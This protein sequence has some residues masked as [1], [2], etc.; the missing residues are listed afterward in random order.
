MIQGLSFHIN[1]HTNCICINFSRSNIQRQSTLCLL[2]LWLPPIRLHPVQTVVI[3]LK[4]DN[5]NQPECFFFHNGSVWSFL[6]HNT[7]EIVLCMRD[8]CLTDDIIRNMLFFYLALSQNVVE[9]H[10]SLFQLNGQCPHSVCPYLLKVIIAVIS[11]SRQ[12]HT[13][14]FFWP[15]W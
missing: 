2:S 8:R 14:S 1:R 5:T 6:Q 4:Q 10:G 9:R 13:T 3:G 15:S 11:P 12:K 7:V